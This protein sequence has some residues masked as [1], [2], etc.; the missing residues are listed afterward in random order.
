MVGEDYSESDRLLRGLSPQPAPP[1]RPQIP[2][3][4]ERQP[5]GEAEA[6]L[7]GG[8]VAPGGGE[9]LD[10][11]AGEVGLHGQLEAEAEAGLALDRDAVEEILAVGLEAVGGVAGGEAGEPMEGEAGEAAEHPF[12][13]GTAD[14][15]ASGHVAAGADHGRSGLGPAHHLLHDP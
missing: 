9:L 5:G 10:A 8:A 13:P 6:A 12:Q 14:L 4:V 7:A 3:Q 15:L 11:L 1:Q 2:P